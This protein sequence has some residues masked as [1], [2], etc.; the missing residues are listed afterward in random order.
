MHNQVA[1]SRA[2][3]LRHPPDLRQLLQSLASRVESN[4]RSGLDAE[5]YGEVLR[6]QAQLLQEV[7]DGPVTVAALAG[8]LGVTAQ[9]VSKVAADLVTRG[10]LE[11]SP[12]PGDGRVRVLRLSARG[13]Q[14]A[15]VQQNVRVAAAREQQRWLGTRDFAELVRLLDALAELYEPPPPD[16]G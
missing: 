3:T 9:A 4:E 10:Y 12:D 6:H 2:M 14:F 11:S 8:R 5:G 7:A 15:A 16:R 1:Y 13:E